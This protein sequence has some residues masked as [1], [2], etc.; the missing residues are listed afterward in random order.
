MVISM[1]CDTRIYSIT[2]CSLLD[3]H[4]SNTY[5]VT[6]YDEHFFHTAIYLQKRSYIER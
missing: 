4:Q 3:G 1:K 5:M 2:L 6:H